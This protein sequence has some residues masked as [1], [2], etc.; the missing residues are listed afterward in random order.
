MK[1]HGKGRIK[2][3]RTLGL[4]DNVSSNGFFHKEAMLEILGSFCVKDSDKTQN[5]VNCFFKK[6]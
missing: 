6:D 4:V 1:E 2:R 5:Q 3:E